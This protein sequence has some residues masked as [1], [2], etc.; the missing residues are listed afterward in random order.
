[1]SAGAEFVER[2][3]ARLLPLGP[4]RA[5]AMFGGWGLVLDDVM[6]GLIA[7][8]RLYF[9]VDT[10]TEPRF[11]AAGSKSFTYTRRGARITMSYREAPDG[12]LDE[13]LLPWANLGL[14]AARRARAGRSKAKRATGRA[15]RGRP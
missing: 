10:E 1:M 3:L 14:D 5:R 8:G 9:K 15:A 13:A 2:A 7:G 4:V 11:V 6:F 12:A